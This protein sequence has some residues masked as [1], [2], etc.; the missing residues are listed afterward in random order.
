MNL[1]TRY[2]EMNGGRSFYAITPP[3][4]YL[5]YQVIGQKYILHEIVAK[6]LP[7]RMLIHDILHDEMGRYR[8]ISASEFKMLEAHCLAH[9][10]RM[11]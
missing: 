10:K 9:F 5:E 4:S 3:D 6:I 1:S 7:E 8:E 2:F 11:S